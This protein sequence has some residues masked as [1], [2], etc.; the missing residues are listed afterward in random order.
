VPFRLL[1]YAGDR[2]LERGRV[3]PEEAGV[4]R[5]EFEHQ[6]DREGDEL[7]GKLGD[8]MKKAA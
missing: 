4:G 8:G 5:V 3:D 1:V 7:W 6:E 2:L